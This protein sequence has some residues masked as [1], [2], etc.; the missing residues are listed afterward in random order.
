MFRLS[1]V[2]VGLLAIA[3]L[4][5]VTM[6]AVA[7]E[8]MGK[9]KSIDTAKNQVVVTDANQK[10]WTFHLAK[11]AKIYVD[12]KLV[13]LSDLKKDENATIRYEKDNAGVLNAMEIRCKTK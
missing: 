2:M 5:G 11:D 13:Q 7:A 3:L 4:V 1:N 8:A 9:I 6:P 10:D 12:D